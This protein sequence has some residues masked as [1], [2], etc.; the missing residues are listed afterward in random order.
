VAR[1][2]EG[3]TDSEPTPSGA[4]D[5]T[6][7]GG[8]PVPVVGSRT[9]SRA[10]RG[11][12]SRRDWSSAT[13]AR[14]GGLGAPAMAS[15]PRA[16]C[17]PIP[18]RRGGTEV[19]IGAGSI[20]GWT[21]PG[22]GARPS[23]GDPGPSHHAAIA[24]RAVESESSGAGGWDAVR[25]GAL[26][27]MDGPSRGGAWAGRRSTVNSRGSVLDGVAGRD[28]S[29]T[30]VSSPP[31]R[32][33]PSPGDTECGKSDPSVMRSGDP[34]VVR[35]G[36]PG[37][38]SGCGGRA[39]ESGESVGPGDSRCRVSPRGNWSRGIGPGRKVSRGGVSN[40]CSSREGSGASESRSSDG[41]P[42]S[43]NWMAGLSF[44]TG[45]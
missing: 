40:A 25:W 10:T 2:A 37:A 19:S 6:G 23:R 45:A 17:V 22:G 36:D 8:S 28:P 39:R 38:T 34:T 18:G 4:V 24:A 12:F 30:E 35:S 3:S 1:E 13:G 27:G 42:V 41:I 7:A 44:T 15:L 9:T 5:S 29:R 26:L 16:E 31:C 11:R 21:G 14:R 32:G 20:P 33:V 43:C